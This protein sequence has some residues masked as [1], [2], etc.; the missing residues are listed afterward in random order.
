[1]TISCIDRIMSVNFEPPSIAI[2]IHRGRVGVQPLLISGLHLVFNTHA[3][4]RQFRVIRSTDRF[5]APPNSQLPP[6]IRAVE[7]CR[8]PTALMC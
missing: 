3:L 1:M 4:P 8:L 5:I 6:P 2:M 7:L